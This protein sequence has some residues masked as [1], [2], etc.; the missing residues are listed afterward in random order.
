M[1]DREI[2]GSIELTRDEVD[3]L[4]ELFRDTYDYLAEDDSGDEGIDDGKD[5]VSGLLSRVSRLK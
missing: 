3:F 1:A 4:I 5:I 2:A